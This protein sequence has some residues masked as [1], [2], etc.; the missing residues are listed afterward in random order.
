MT[1]PQTR[2]C[3]LRYED[4]V[5]QPVEISQELCRFLDI[6]FHPDMA[7]PYK[8]K[9]RKMTDGIHAV[10]TMLGDMKFHQHSGIDPTLA[11][12]WKESL[13]EDFLSDIAWEI[14]ERLGYSRLNVRSI[15]EPRRKLEGTT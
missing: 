2:Q 1:V 4:L 8:N 6:P 10:S 12:R 13:K 11:E 3:R 7:R 9:D 15:A 14:A 5:K